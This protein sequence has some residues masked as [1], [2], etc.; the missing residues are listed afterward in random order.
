MTTQLWWPTI[1]RTGVGGGPEPA[2]DA[3]GAVGAVTDGQEPGIGGASLER[4]AG[5][6]GLDRM[7]GG[8][9]PAPVVGG[10]A[11]ERVAGRAGLAPVLALPVRRRGITD[12]QSGLSCRDEH[13]A[14]GER[15]A[16]DGERS[17]GSAGPRLQGGRRRRPWRRGLPDAGMATAEYAVVLL[18]AVGFAG[19]LIVIL[20]SDEVRGMLTGLIREA[21]TV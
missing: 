20:S 11:L 15:I 12:R 7:V 21:L 2:A 9:G 5:G 17:P 13:P 10:A 6:A 14:R 8:A 1:I 3:A 16:V 4:E 19:L 18:A